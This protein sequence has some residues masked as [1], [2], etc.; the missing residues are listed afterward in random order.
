MRLVLAKLFVRVEAL[1]DHH[2][3]VE[4]SIGF[5]HRKPYIRI[6]RIAE[7]GESKASSSLLIIPNVKLRKS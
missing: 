6:I 2:Q 7:V 5:G 4:P 3:V 1:V